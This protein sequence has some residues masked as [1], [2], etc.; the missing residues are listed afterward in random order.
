MRK[1][2]FN[3]YPVF[4]LRLSDGRYVAYLDCCP[5]KGRPIT[6][7]GFRLEEDVIICPFHWA[8]FD[9]KT[10]RLVSAPDSKTSCPPD[11]SLIKLVLDDKGEP[12]RFEGE[13]RMP[14]LPEKRKE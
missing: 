8:A 13:P 9:L 4:S 1:F 7:D 12:L 2:Q 11:C 3:G 14:R 5:H 10:G 6:A